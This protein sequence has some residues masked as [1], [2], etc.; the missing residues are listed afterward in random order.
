MYLCNI[1]KYLL[2]FEKGGKEVWEKE[3]KEIRYERE[4]GEGKYSHTK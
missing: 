4:K 3:G 1:F 2:R